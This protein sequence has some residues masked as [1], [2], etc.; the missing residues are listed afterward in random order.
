MATLIGPFFFNFG[1]AVADQQ[2]EC[3]NIF[4]SYLAIGV[5]IALGLICTPYFVKGLWSF[6][7]FRY[8]PLGGPLYIVF[9]GFFFW[10]TIHSFIV[11][12]S[13]YRNAIGRKKKQIKLFLLA[14]GIA[15]S[16]GG[17]L[18]LQ[19]FGIPF[20][21]YGVYLILA[22]VLII[23]YAIHRYKF[24]DLPSLAKKTVVFAGL[25]G[26]VMTVVSIV[27]AFIQSELTRHFSFGPTASGILSGIIIIL[28]YEPTRRLLVF[29]TDKFLFQKKY[30]I[31]EI[32]K[33]LA[34]QSVAILD[35]RFLAFRIV[36]TLSK[37]MSLESVAL[38]VIDQKEEDY[39][40]IQSLGIK[41]APQKISKDNFLIEFMR[42]RKSIFD[43]EAEQ[44]EK[45]PTSLP[46]A[47]EKLNASVVIP[48]IIQEKLI[49]VLTLGKKKS[50]DL[51]T[52]ED[53]DHFEILKGALATGVSN[54]RLFEMVIKTR[55]E[56]AQHSKMAAIGTL[57]SGIEH[58]ARNPMNNAYTAADHLLLDIEDNLLGEVPDKLKDRIQ[59]DL[60]T[61][62]SEITRA[63]N[64]MQ[65]L[66]EFSKP[67]KEFK[68]ELASFNEELDK[69]LALVVDPI[70]T[71]KVKVVRSIENELKLRAD[72]KMLS[73]ILFN[74][75]TN[76][77]HAMAGQSKDAIL[78]ISAV[79]EDNKTIVKIADTG[80][81]IPDDKKDML[82]VPFYTTKD[83]TRDESGGNIKGTGLGLYICKQIMDRHSGKISFLSERDKGTTFFLEFPM[84]LES[85]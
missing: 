59:K 21:S 30:N 49:G 4:R 50:D 6:G 23:G 79:N 82:F 74:L 65:N 46:S 31:R 47:L 18:F 66:T 25:L 56:L 57:A 73:Q 38:I 12:A 43:L 22:Y 60:V 33:D 55:M 26:M 61:V 52:R 62:T 5:A 85:V 75:I 72:R 84:T 76:A 35:I 83:V 14:T 2:K 64:I 51:Y 3:K 28:L 13:K 45:V 20:P 10:C 71:H 81:G 24:L 29:A 77:C 69:V 67:S 42:N 53:L 80:G 9:A 70:R 1:C 32:I 36:N 7:V 8:Q 44:I 40:M 78:S 27:T 63:A 54:A 41:N 16:G 68:S 48:L 39:N 19:A 11:A 37:A 34:N 17:S 58:E 15:Y